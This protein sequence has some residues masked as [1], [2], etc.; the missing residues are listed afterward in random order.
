M[1]HDEIQQEISIIK[2]MIEK[3]K[4]QTAESGHLFIFMGIVAVVFVLVISMLELYQLHQWVLPTMIALAILNG[5]LGFLVV[6]KAEQP[7]KVT[8]YPRTVVLHLWVICSVNLLLLTFLF[9]FL[10]VYSFQ[11][12]P[13][14]V[15]LTVGIGVFMT[16]II[17]EMRFLQWF[18]I[19]W[20]V[21]ACLMAVIQ[22]QY[23]FVIMIAT[24]IIGWI[25][26]GFILNK[27]YQ[28]RS[29]ENES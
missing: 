18:S 24:I 19:T 26:P 25:I 12:L 29:K 20:W 23:R 17:Y 28:K 13:V 22:S 14:L 15:N 21:G 6:G 9:P 27:Q 2:S 5:I 1:N 3:T 4:K 11:A 7:E 16:G 10:K 8:T